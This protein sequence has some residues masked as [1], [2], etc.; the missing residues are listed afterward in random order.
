[1]VWGERSQVSENSLF[2]FIDLVFDGNQGLYYLLS[3]YQVTGLF[4]YDLES[5]YEKR[6]FHKNDFMP[7]K[8]D[9]SPARRE[10]VAC[11]HEHDG[12]ANLTLL[13]VEGKV[14][15]S[16]TAGDS[17]DSHPTFHPG[18]PSLI[19]YQTSGITRNADGVMLSISPES[20][21]AMD[22]ESGKITEL[23]DDP[24]YD[25]LSPKADESGNLYCI[26]RPYRSSHIT[27]WQRLTE[28]LLFPIHFLVAIVGFIN[29]FNHLFGNKAQKAGGPDEKQ[30]NPQ[31]HIHVFGEAINL[32]KVLKAQNKPDKISLVP[33]T[34]ELICLTTEGEITVI[35]H[36]VCSFDILADGSLVYSNG[37]KVQ[38]TSSGNA[39]TIFKHDIIEFIKATPYS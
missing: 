12:S 34:Y 1:M 32:A 30:P 18:E 28:V 26:R 9:F 27:M 19:F 20:V 11:C 38:H 23:L 29:L 6:L 10:F 2:R 21:N 33:K 7:Y 22:L 14:K 16:L 31:K 25:Y 36:N 8:M 39:K 4:H 15:H 3:S 24:A 5:R 37:F 35:A 17:R 13:N